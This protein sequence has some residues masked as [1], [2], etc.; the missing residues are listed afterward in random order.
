MAFRLE[1]KVENQELS[2]HESVRLTC[3]LRNESAEAAELPSPYDR[4]GAFRIA[5]CDTGRTPLRT[6]SRLSRQAFL[7]DGRVDSSLDLDTLA[8]GQEWKWN[9]DLSSFHYPIPPGEYLVNAIYDYGP[10]GVRLDSGFQELRVAQYPVIA[11]EAWR[12]NP[13]LDGLAL[14]IEADTDDGPAWFL[15]QHNYDRPMGAWYSIRVAAGEEPGTPPYCATC[16]FFQTDSADPF[17]EKWVLWTAEG[18]LRARRYDCGAPTGRYRAAPIPDDRTV[19]RAAIRTAEDSLYVFFRTD[20][21]LLECYRFD[22]GL[23][24]VFEHGLRAPLAPLSIGADTESIHLAMPWRGVFYERL[25]FDG[26]PLERLHVFRSRLRPVSIQYD[27]A[28][29]RIKALFCDHPHGRVV[30]MAVID[31]AGD[32]ITECR[33]DR[34]GIRDDF[35]ELSFEQ[36]L[37]GRFHLLAS[38]AGGKLY[39]LFEGSGPRLIAEGEPRFF[40]LVVAPLRV[41]LGCYRRECGYRFLQFRRKQRGSKLLG[42]DPHG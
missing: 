7:S 14:L 12:D 24:K 23:R 40:P 17:F 25:R 21:G 33:I 2:P 22:E 29:R 30:Q 27:P 20:R 37:K 31:F 11:V 5:L 34:A 10:A 13:V 6:M 39:Y 9:L 32:L 28:G 16:N 35:T 18:E 38:T 42:L 4:S 26:R 8:P 41:Y 3:R 1:V 36:D 15:R 19:E